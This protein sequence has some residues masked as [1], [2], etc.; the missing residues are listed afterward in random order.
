M[1]EHTRWMVLR[2]TAVFPAP[3]HTSVVCERDMALEII[4]GQ[5]ER[6]NTF[7]IDQWTG[8]SWGRVGSGRYLKWSHIVPA[9]MMRSPSILPESDKHIIIC[10]LVP[11]FFGVRIGRF[12]NKSWEL[13]SDTL[14]N[15]IVIP[16][17][18]VQGWLVLP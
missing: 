11:Q 4:S 13:F 3:F 18:Y 14:G 16:D 1:N 5:K 2:D 17:K 12:H 9:G 7:V 10:S 8:R 15:W 6:R